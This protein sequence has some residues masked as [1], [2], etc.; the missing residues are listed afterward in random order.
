M[1]RANKVSGNRSK[2]LKKDDLRHAKVKLN[3]D[4]ELIIQYN[5]GFREGKDGWRADGKVRGGEV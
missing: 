5:G 2:D 1:S 3:A 4:G